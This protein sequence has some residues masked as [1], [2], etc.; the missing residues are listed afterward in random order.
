M[1]VLNSYEAIKEAYIKKGDV[2]SGRMQFDYLKQHGDD[3]AGT[4]LSH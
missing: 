3:K 4:D 2:S 1:V